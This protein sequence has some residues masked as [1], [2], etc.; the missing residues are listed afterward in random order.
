[1]RLI[2]SDTLLEQFRTLRDKWGTESAIHRAVRGA[3]VDCILKTRDAPTIDAVPVKHGVWRRGENFGG[4]FRDCSV[5]NVRQYKVL[6]W[7]YCPNCGAKMDGDDNDKSGE[8]HS[9]TQ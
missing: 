8:V 2:D 1:M 3:L 9:Q 6:F 5:C 4:E 7:K